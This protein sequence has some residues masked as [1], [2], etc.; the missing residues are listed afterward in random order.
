MSMSSSLRLMK[1]PATK[2]TRV[3]TMMAAMARHHKLF[4][5]RKK[6]AAKGEESAFRRLK[7][8]PRAK[9]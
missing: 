7:R 8:I 1:K 6:Q 3:E 9:R 2:K 4:Q 5:R